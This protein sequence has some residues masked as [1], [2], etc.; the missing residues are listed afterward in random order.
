MLTIPITVLAIHLVTDFYCQTDWMGSNKSKNWA[1]LTAH[2][3]IYS[4]VFLICYGWRFAGITFVT[5]FATDALTSRISGVFFRRWYDD[6][7]IGWDAGSECGKFNIFVQ[8][9]AHWFFSVI[10]TD[11]WIHAVTLALTWSYCFG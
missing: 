7:M 3:T 9:P 6:L 8:P 4:T 5:H 10:G 11:Q 2:V 1:A